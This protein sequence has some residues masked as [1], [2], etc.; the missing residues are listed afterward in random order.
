MRKVILQQIVSLDGYA[1]GPNGDVAFLPASTR[2]D[3]KWDAEQTALFDTVD[4][5]VLGR[6]T[7]EVFS[8]IWPTRTEGEEKEFADKFNGLQKI[9]FSRTLERAPWGNWPA[10][11]IVRG[12]PADEIAKLKKQPGKHMLISGSISIGQ[13]LTEANVVDE[14]HVVVCPIV[15]GGGRP[16]FRDKSHGKQFELIDAHG[17]DRG[18]VSLLYRPTK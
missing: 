15:M 18:A 13:A 6:V 12:N 14:Y 3:R 8:H 16:L 7:Y 5:L 1:A 11:R 9:V 17:L 10:G 4:T 2:G